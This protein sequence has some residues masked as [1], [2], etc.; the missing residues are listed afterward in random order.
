MFPVP[1]II[2]AIGHSHTGYVSRTGSDV[3][4]I[5]LSR[6]NRIFSRNPL[7]PLIQ[8]MGELREVPFRR[9]AYS[10]VSWIF[11]ANPFGASLSSGIGERK[12]YP[13][14]RYVGVIP[15]GIM[16]GICGNAE[17]EPILDTGFSGR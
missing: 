16:N 9:L 4:P 3:R 5:R 6:S 11:G 12:P 14:S 13:H 1:W 8:R 7:I 17:D 2:P 10:Q 15:G